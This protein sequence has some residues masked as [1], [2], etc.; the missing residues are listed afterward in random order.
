LEKVDN[1]IQ[2]SKPSFWSQLEAK[3]DFALSR[4]K[5]RPGFEQAA[6]TDRNRQE[7][8]VLKSAE[9]RGYIKL[10]AKDLF[11]FS[12]I[13]G[14]RTVQQIL[15]EYFRKHGTLAF[16]RLGTLV[17]ELLQAGFLTE[18]P[19]FF[20]QR[21]QARLKQSKRLA[22]AVDFAKSLPYRQWPIRDFDPK[23]DWLYRHGLSI[24]F[25]RP[26]QAVAGAV[27]LAGLAAFLLTLH[28]GGFSLVSTGGSLI[29]GLGLL[30]VLNYASIISHELAHALACKHFGRKVNGGGTMLYLGLPA[31][32]V[33][34]T[35]AWMLPK[36]QRMTVSA[37]GAFAQMFLA[38]VS[39]GVAWAAPHLPLSPLFFKFAVLSYLSI[40]LNLNPFLELDGYFLLIDWLEMPVL[41]ERARD[42]VKK[43]L[44]SK[45]RSKN[46]FSSEEKTYAAFGLG[47]LA[48]SA[49]ALAVVAYS[50]RSKLAQW[51]HVFIAF[52]SHRSRLLL[53][54]LILLLL[55]ALAAFSWKRLA[56]V[57]KNVWDWFTRMINERPGPTAVSLVLV[58]M[59]AAFGLAWVRGIPGI[60]AALLLL[61][62]TLAVYHRVYSYY[63]GSNLWMVLAGLMAVSL[64]SLGKRYLSQVGDRAITLAGSAVLF[65]ASYLQFSLTSLRRWRRWQRWLWGGLWMSLLM[66]AGAVTHSSPAQMLSALLS[67]SALLMLLSPVWMNQGS[68]LEYFWYSFLLQTLAWNAILFSG[69]VRFAMLTALLG[70]FS[71]VWL[72]LVIKS[73][74]WLPEAAVFEPAAS[75]RR[76]MR[77]AAVRIYTSARGYFAAFYGEAQ[78]RAMDDRLNLVLI[79]KGWPIRL[80]GNGSEE[81]FE[82]S[83]GIVERS[84]A[85]R[86]MLDELHGYIGREAGAYFARK[87][88]RASYE[89]L[90][91]EE[92]EIAQ[93]YLMPGS[94]W[95]QG[96]A[97]ADLQ[98]ERSDAQNVVSSVARFWDLSEEEAAVLS[99]R[100][101]EEKKHAGQTIIK[102][103]EQGDKFY[104]IKSGRVQIS[105]T[106]GQGRKTDLATLSKGDYFGEI[107]L[108]KKVPRT[109]T[110]V[111]L[112]ECSLLIL[113]KGDFE[114]MMSQRINI[115]EKVD[116]LIENRGFLARL[117]L[118]SEFAPAQIAMAASRLLPERYQAGQNVVTQGQMG[119]SFYIIKEGSLEVTVEKE[120]QRR[121]VAEL[122]PGEYFGEIALLLDVPRTA[123]VTALSDCLVLRL[124]QE[125]FRNLLGEH[126][127]FAKS[128][129]QTSSR[130]ISDTR[131]K[132]VR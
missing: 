81:R 129:E 4:P 114:L 13:D 88:F 119:D 84:Q 11:L 89:S 28:Q 105:A 60:M 53:G 39:A 108:V 115:A 95:S 42:F 107:A 69:Q 103:G 34:T 22:R 80:Y 124:R 57:M 126:L 38:G 106:D 102:Q 6:F 72:Y 79:E 58:C 86:G 125:D 85:F 117:P 25:L 12:L 2:K 30:I 65:A 111:A 16:S 130:R 109:A 122:G 71:L 21:L 97:M 67:L 64:A 47:G 55:A 83:T 3:L 100:L 51:L 110:A 74:R 98:K 35:D 8:Y 37:V 78:A 101:K 68:S 82:R 90:Y 36:P 59:A 131:H 87:A 54:W 27:S 40:F 10:G 91:W 96:L 44:I 77:R 23:V 31:F 9:G 116:R 70:F 50:W 121:R 93:Q 19:V 17:R 94:V 20:Y 5:L 62:G 14:Q 127:Y 112:S 73:A 104:I 7:Y 56:V 41:K 75:E 1:P 18:D 52:T 118:F 123:S 29:L 32:Y 92:R 24:F 48:W 61:A 26:V 132:T 66:A 120:G 128:L 46:P 49:L 33:D 76:R 45:L 15:A 43:E 63:R 99:A 113:E